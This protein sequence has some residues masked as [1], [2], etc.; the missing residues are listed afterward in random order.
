MTQSLKEK[1]EEF[2]KAKAKIVPTFP[3]TYSIGVSKEIKARFNMIRK[4][5]KL[6]A[7]E[8]LSILLESY[9]Q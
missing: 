5:H 4:N 3:K 6:T 7:N 2:S 9:P 1:L 8:L